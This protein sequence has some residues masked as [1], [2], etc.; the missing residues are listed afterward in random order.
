MNV[1]QNKFHEQADARLDRFRDLV[2]AVTVSDPAWLAGFLPWLRREGNLRTAPLIGAAEFVAAR[3]G[4]PDP[5]GQVP[6]VVDGVLQRADEPGEIL[7]YYTSRYGM[8]LPKGLKKGVARAVLRLYGEY[9]WAKYDRVEAAFRFARVLD[10]VHPASSDETQR[11]LFGYLH[12]EMRGRAGEIPAELAMLRSRSELTAVPLDGRRAALLAPDG[13]DR[14]R[15][16]GMTWR[17]VAGW[18]QRPLDAD[19][20]SQIIPT[21]G[22]QALL[23]NLRNFDDAG[24]SDEVAERV[25][26]RI[27]D[28]EKVAGSRLFPFQIFAAYKALESLR[29]GQPLEKALQASLANVPSLPGR[30]LVLVD[31]SPSMFPGYSFSSK[32]EREHVANNDLATLFGGAVALRAADATL[33]GYGAQ[34]YRVP[35]RRGGALLRLMGQF[36]SVDGTDTFGAAGDHFAGHDRVVIVTDEQNTAHRYRSIDEV[37]PTTVP[38]YTWNIAGYRVGS[39]A[40]GSGTRHTFGGLTDQA[41]RAVGL[42]EQGRSQSWPW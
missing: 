22:Y 1:R 34:S 15:A 16:A 30:T 35:F 17:A 31:Q 7:A 33:V 5:A 14:L 8:S 6:E 26:A 24:V 12:G 4:Q 20:W 38:V 40:S 27:A 39:T 2:A 28:P 25:A 19:V 3:R 18:L 13:T 42:I 21:M 11:T 37:V 29:W 10:L 9:G 36:H 41:F 32:Q 23:T